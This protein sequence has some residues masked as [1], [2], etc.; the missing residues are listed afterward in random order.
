M[1]VNAK[2][3]LRATGNQIIKKMLADVTLGIPSSNAQG[4]LTYKLTHKQST[5]DIRNQQ[6]KEINVKNGH[7]LF[8][9]P[10]VIAG[11]GAKF[12]K[13]K[14]Y[15]IDELRSKLEENESVKVQVLIVPIPKG[16]SLNYDLSITSTPAQLIEELISNAELNL[17]RYY[18]NGDE[19]SYNFS[20][21]GLNYNITF[22]EHQ[23]QKG[24]I[25]YLVN[26]NSK[27]NKGLPIKKHSIPNLSFDDLTKNE[28]ALQII[29][30]RYENLEN[31]NEKQ[32]EEISRLRTENSDKQTGTIL[33]ILAQIITAFGVNLVTGD[34]K[35]GWIVFA[36][37]MIITIF[38]L[39]FSMHKNN[40]I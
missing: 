9:L 8:L 6:L 36:A 13:I 28:G 30:S 40:E 12:F 5:T 24:D 39:Y 31:Q 7:T 29:L 20:N 17:D 23:I 22:F 38:S 25:L 27:F 32:K 3:P 34:D 14:K 1:E 18:S 37:G 19:I 2:L 16:D 15:D 35:S 33:L 21:G 10:D 26:N 11:G 4:S